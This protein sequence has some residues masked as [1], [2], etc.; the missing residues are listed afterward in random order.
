MGFYKLNAHSFWGAVLREPCFINTM[1]GLL[2]PLYNY[3]SA[4]DFDLPSENLVFAPV[5][6]S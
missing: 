6:T 4:A 1:L 3:K 5:T 2:P